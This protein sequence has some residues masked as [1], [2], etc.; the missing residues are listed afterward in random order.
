MAASPPLLNFDS[1]L[2]PIPGD[3]P[4]GGSIPFDVKEKLEEDRREEDPADYAADD[5]MRPEEFKKADW[6]HI[7]RL[8]QEILTNKS[9][10]LLLAARLM[11]A[12]VKQ[13]GFSG[14]RDGLRLMRLLVEQC[15]DRLHP[16]IEA[17]DDVE[18]RAGPFNWLDDPDHGA[19]FPNTVRAV[20]MVVGAGGG[21]GWRAWKQSQEGHGDI[22]REDLD[23]AIAAAPLERCA[24]LGEDLKLA[25]EELN[26]LA[27]ALSAKMGPSAP[28]LT[29]IRQA[30]D[31]CR[32]L[33]NQIL[34]MKGASAPAAAAPS[35]DKSAAATG[36]PRPVAATRAEAY[37]QL[38]EAAALLQQLEPHSPIPYFVQRAVRLGELSFPQLIK[39]LIRDGNVLAELN[40]EMGIA[41]EPPPAQ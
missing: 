19:L 25:A 3:N 26:L 32:L 37:R 21:F 16:P 34:K 10:D 9:K 30:M 40:R 11:E 36:S 18:M 23:K 24:T 1:L 39:A 27:Q 7:A 31:D 33:L 28:G 35:G 29:A 2:A 17:P 38:E 41:E 8:T 6:P 5:P 15:W 14:L 13:H 12:L 4:A 20:P 22:K